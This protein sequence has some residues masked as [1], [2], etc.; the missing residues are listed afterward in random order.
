[1]SL[2]FDDTIAALA[3]AAGPAGEAIVRISGPAV[4]STLLNAF[5]PNDETAFRSA[6]TAAC[7]AGHIRIAALKSLLPARLYFW[8][9]GRSYTGEPMAEIHTLGSPPLVEATLAELHRHGARPARPGEFTLRA[10]LA[11][12]IDLTQAEAVLG[13]VDAHDHAELA[14]ALDQ[15][16][17][18]LSGPIGRIRED[19]LLLLADLEAE[20]D[21]VDEDIEF[22]PRDQVL[23][24][25]ERAH[26]YLASLQSQSLERMRSTGRPRVV[27]AGLPNAGKSTLFNALV[28]RDAALV[29]AVQGTTRDYL[30]AEL[31]WHGLGHRRL[32][33]RGCRN[34]RRGA[35][36]AAGTTRAGR[37]HHLVHGRRLRRSGF[38]LR[39]QVAN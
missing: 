8:P 21:F 33:R 39:H 32:V 19:L 7:H 28:G 16:A 31:D 2:Q 9:S 3:S 24:R 13:V 20:L 6:K 15:L 30:S 37:S 26:D 10:F 25:L 34:R 5:V 18:G 11:G 17:G 1:M 22:V 4:R 35:A 29:S 23:A 38:R 14:S 12:R 36:P 27:L